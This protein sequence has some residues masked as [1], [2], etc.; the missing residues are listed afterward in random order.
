MF[1]EV[2][3]PADEQSL[4]L[5]P[6]CD[7]VWVHR[8]GD[9]VGV[10]LVRAVRA[11]PFPPGEVDAFV[12]GEAH[13][14]K[15]LRRFLRIDQ[16]L[17]RHQLSISGYWRSGTDEDG[18]QAAK[19]AWNRQLDA[20]ETAAQTAALTGRASPRTEQPVDCLTGPRSPVG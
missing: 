11:L 19:P 9:P 7:P 15:A 6:G 3:G 16:A 14:V 8:G 10:R 20:E 13:F 4:A 2:D 18:W 17:P 1:L 12:H 5:P